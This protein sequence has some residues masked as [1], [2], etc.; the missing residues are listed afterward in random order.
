MV[1]AKERSFKRIDNGHM[2]PNK[3]VKG[4]TIMK[5]TLSSNKHVKVHFAESEEGKLTAKIISTVWYKENEDEMKNVLHLINKLSECKITPKIVR[6][7][8]KRTNNVYY[9][10]KLCNCGSLE[11]QVQ[12]QKRLTEDSIIAVIKG[13]VKMLK[14]LYNERYFYLYLDPSH[15]LMHEGDNGKIAYRLIGM[16]YVREI[17]EETKASIPEIKYSAPEITKGNFKSYRSQIWSLGLIIYYMAVGFLPSEIDENYIKKRKRNEDIKFPSELELSSKL[18]DLIHACLKYKRKERIELKNIL[19]HP[20]ILKETSLDKSNDHSGVAEDRKLTQ[21]EKNELIRVDLY[22]Y[23]KIL[24]EDTKKKYEENGWVYDEENTLR[25][26]KRDTLDPYKPK[27]ITPLAIGGFGH[28]YLCTNTKTNKLVVRKVI[29]ADN[30]KVFELLIGEVEIMRTLKDSA[31]TIE[32]IES[33]V[34]ENELNIILEYC[35]GGD[36]HDYALKF[37]DKNPIP[38]EDLNLIAWNIGCGLNDMHLLNM[39]HRDIKPKNILL[40]KDGEKGRLIDVKLCDYGLGKKAADRES[41]RS[42]NLVGTYTYFAPELYEILSKRRNRLQTNLAYNEKV[43]VWSY[44]ILLYFLIF[45]KTPLDS[46]RPEDLMINEKEISYPEFPKELK[47]FVDL[48]KMCL[49]YDPDKRPAFSEV[50]KHP[51]FDTVYISEKGNAKKT[52]L[53]RKTI[54]QNGNV[55]LA[56]KNDVKYAVKTI[57]I[58]HEDM[59]VANAVVGVLFKLRNS[60]NVVHLYD[61]FKYEKNLYLVMDYYSGGNLEKFILNREK[62]K[63]P[64]TPKE[65]VFIAYEILRGIREVHA[66]NI[67]HRDINPTNV[68]LNLDPDTG[69]ISQLALCDFGLAKVLLPMDTTITTLGT[70]QSPEQRLHKKYD[71]SSDMWSFGM[72][73]YF[74]MFG[75]HIY[76]IVNPYSLYSQGK[77]DFDKKREKNV[78]KEVFEI[79]KKCIVVKPD[80]RPKAEALLREKVFETLHTKPQ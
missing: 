24:I 14:K 55:Y 9:F 57:E 13:V 40:I 11:Y 39:M 60:K 63:K 67:I 73:L 42:D 18:K 28:I 51:Y 12:N 75:V 33:F 34:Y 8:I 31:F 69:N 35:N 36:L 17:G 7:P 64:L 76:D 72:L 46:L 45:R 26:T 19:K 23:I 66:R 2:N 52:Y 16:R 71:S 78:S 15:I 41:L 22:R 6:S 77:I 65:Q 27:Q 48:I 49:V 37:T 30:V 10:I 56:K 20:F 54:S 1:E 3:E 44:G 38:L 47:S 4:Y 53:N 29:K 61:F 58:Y 68:V 50:L 62:D 79:M 25:V 43:D 32:F 70:Y 59:K 74:I 5:E 21:K 80:L